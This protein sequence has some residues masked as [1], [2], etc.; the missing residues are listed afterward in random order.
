MKDIEVGRRSGRL[1]VI[2]VYKMKRSQRSAVHVVCQCDC[3]NQLDTTG[4]KFRRGKRKS[5]GCLR[6]RYRVSGLSK[7]PQYMMFCSARRRAAAHGLPF[8][9]KLEHIVIPETC[10]VF[11]FTLSTNGHRDFHP[12]LDRINPSLGYVP[13]NIRVISFRANRIK[14]DAT[15]EELQGVLEYMRGT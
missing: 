11:G 8:A 7:T 6:P 3:G 12:S 9:L 13:S 4:S 5:C 10:P 14:S 2:K 1:T 15:V